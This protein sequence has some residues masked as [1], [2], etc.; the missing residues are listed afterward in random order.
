MG[1][2]AIRPSQETILRRTNCLSIDPGNRVDIGCGRFPEKSDAFT[3]CK[4]QADNNC[5]DERSIKNKEWH[6]LGS[7]GGCTAQDAGKCERLAAVGG[8]SQVSVHDLSVAISFAPGVLVVLAGIYRDGI[9][10]CCLWRFD[11]KV[12]GLAG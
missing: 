6:I 5:Q 9:A 10:G 4:N 11:D 8:K 7:S 2:Q 1:R 12:K 3:D